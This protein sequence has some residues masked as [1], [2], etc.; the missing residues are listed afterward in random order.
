MTLI[1][2]IKCWLTVS[3]YKDYVVRLSVC[4]HA[5]QLSPTSGQPY[6]QLALLEASRGDRL[7]TVFHYM[8]SIAVRHMFPAATSN[9]ALTLEKCAAHQYVLSFFNK[10]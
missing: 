1:T 9:L 4:R 5:V 10:F 2:D 6:N 8:R 3:D 7:S